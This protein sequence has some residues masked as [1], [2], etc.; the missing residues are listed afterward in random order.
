[1]LGTPQKIDRDSKMLG[2]YLGVSH[3]I[4]IM[5]GSATMLTFF[6]GS[7]RR[8]FKL[9]ELKV[10]PLVWSMILTLVC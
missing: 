7:K 4:S 10:L 6:V 8:A 3:V 9:V 2:R 5:L 1:M